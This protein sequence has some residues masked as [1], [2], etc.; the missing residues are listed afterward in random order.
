MIQL[1]NLNTVTFIGVLALAVSALA[2]SDKQREFTAWIS[3]HDQDVFGLGMVD[4]DLSQLPWASASF[5]DDRALILD[6]I[7]AAKART[8]WN[9]LG[10][11]PSEA[12]LQP[13]LDQFRT[14]IEVFAIADT[15]QN[16][17]D[18]WSYGGKPEHWTVCPI[19]DIYQ[20][21]Y[22]CVLCHD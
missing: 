9:R 22:G 21:S 11:A 10:F 3:S 6:V 8:G 5:D 19:H 15:S 7:V 18:V 20:H 16:N 2:K 12:W 1:S 14:L 4:F 17:A 13:R